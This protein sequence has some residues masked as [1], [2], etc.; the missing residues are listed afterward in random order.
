[1]VRDLTLWAVLAV[2]VPEGLLT[3]RAATA[4][5]APVRLITVRWAVAAVLIRGALEAAEATMRGTVP[6]V[7]PV[8]TAVV[9][10]EA[11]EVEAARPQVVAV[12]MVA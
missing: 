2:L 12:E 4:L 10:A 1:M 8:E 9:T 3:R 11:A 5:L 7:A 6:V